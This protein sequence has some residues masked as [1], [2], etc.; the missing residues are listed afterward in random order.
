[1][2]D[3]TPQAGVLSGIEQVPPSSLFLH[4]ISGLS[5]LSDA[6]SAG[7]LGSIWSGATGTIDPWTKSKMV[8]DQATALQNAGM[9]ANAAQSQAES[10][11]TNSL[12]ASGADPGQI[13]GYWAD[14]GT[15]LTW[16]LVAGVLYLLAQVFIVG[17]AWE[18]VLSP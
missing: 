6:L 3:S 13:P 1:M 18:D 8:S 11:V 9:N 15:V 10:D 4:P 12:Q 7:V 14:I 2:S 17:K 5:T 16:A